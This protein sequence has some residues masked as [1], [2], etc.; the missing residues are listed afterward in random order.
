MGMCFCKKRRTNIITGTSDDVG[1]SFLV[2]FLISN[3]DDFV[4][5]IDVNLVAD[6]LIL[7]VD[8][9]FGAE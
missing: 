5:L 6:S 1:S 3:I 2:P 7:Q 9:C 8:L 4:G